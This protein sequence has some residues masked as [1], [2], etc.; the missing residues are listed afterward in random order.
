MPTDPPTED[1][2]WQRIWGA[3]LAALKPILGDA[4]DMV[5][6]GVGRLTRNELNAEA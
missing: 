4:G 1:D 2:S 5:Y 3:R 6:Q